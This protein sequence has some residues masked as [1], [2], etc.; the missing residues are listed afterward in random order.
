MVKRCLEEAASTG[1]EVMVDACVGCHLQFLPEESKYPF[2]V[3]HVL[4]LIGEAMGI[5]YEDKIKRF[6]RYGDID[7]IMAEARENIESSP[8]KPNFVAYL[9]K[10]MFVRSTT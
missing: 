1:A 10:R 8:Y 4:T 5:N 2:Q 6:Y 7:R 3:E 9:A